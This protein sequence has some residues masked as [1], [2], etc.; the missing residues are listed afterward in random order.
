MEYGEVLKRMAPCGLDCGRCI[1]YQGGEI[2]ELSARLLKLLGNY[3]RVATIMQKFNPA[4]AAYKDFEEILKTFAQASC[5]G[6]R[7]ANNSCPTPCAVKTCHKEKAVE[8]CFQCGD[9]PCD[10]QDKIPVGER[11]LKMNQRLQEI[12]VVKYYEEQ[13]KLPRY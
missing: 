11:W 3:Q 12:G 4:F 10:Q 2:Q 13:S 5:S 7:T 8:F 1:G 6:C 9:F